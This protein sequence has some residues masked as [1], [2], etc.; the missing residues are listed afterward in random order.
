MS[1]DSTLRHGSKGC[2]ATT[3]GKMAPARRSREVQR[4][5]SHSVGEDKI[6]SGVLSGNVRIV[7]VLR[8]NCLLDHAK[9][10][11]VSAIPQGQQAVP[12]EAADG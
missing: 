7:P 6:P 3:S 5:S 8:V 2:E 9:R 10:I 1:S 4:Q 11:V 12:S